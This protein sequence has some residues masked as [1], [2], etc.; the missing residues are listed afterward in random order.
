MLLYATNCIPQKQLI[1]NPTRASSKNTK[2]DAV[3]KFAN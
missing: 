1:E 2:L 3:K